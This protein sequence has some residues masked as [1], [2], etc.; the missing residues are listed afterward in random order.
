MLAKPVSVLTNDIIVT[1]LTI[2]SFGELIR[3]KEIKYL[4]FPKYQG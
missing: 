3:V 1:L 4:H 2:D